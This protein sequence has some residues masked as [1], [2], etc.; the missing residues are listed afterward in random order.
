M[1]ESLIERGGVLVGPPLEKMKDLFRWVADDA[2]KKGLVKSADAF[3]EA[4]IEREDQ[5]ST[6]L[7]PGIAIPHARSATVSQ[8]FVYL[9]VATRGI[10]FAG[11]GSKVKIAFL[12]GAP[13]QTQHYLDIMATIA[14]LLHKEDFRAGLMAAADPATVMRQVREGS[15]AAQVEIPGQRN[16]HALV[17]VLNDRSAMETAMEV[18]VEV[19]V[20]TPQVF[21]TSN[22][23]AR[24]ALNFPFLSLFSAR[25]DRTASQTLFGIVFDDKTAGRLYAHLRKEGIDIEQPGAGVLF[26][27]PLG[28]LYGGK[29][30]D[31]Y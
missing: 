17:L 21:D 25:G 24:I 29:D 23:A 28:P 3:Y 31:Y 13:P 12:F 30:A 11:P 27:F 1:L 14:R 8:E 18:A 5:V 16:R 6:E 26:S 22:V 10:K 4:L 9:V 2:A 15:L 20:K 19:G 7:E